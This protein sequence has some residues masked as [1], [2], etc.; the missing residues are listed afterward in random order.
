MVRRI[1]L[2]ISTTLIAVAS[3]GVFALGLGEISLKSNLNQPVNAEIQLLEIRDLTERDI[4]VRLGSQQDF[5]RL[6]LDRSYFLTDLKFSV[7]LE[8]TSGAVILVTSN[9]PVREPFLDFVIEARWPSGRLLREYT[10]LLD[11]PVFAKGGASKIA[12]ARSTTNNSAQPSNQQAVRSAPSQGVNSRSSYDQGLSASNRPSVSRPAYDGDTYQVK[13]NDTLWEIALEVR[14]DRDVSVHQ[15]MMALQQSNPDAFINGNIN[16]LKKGQVLRIPDSDEIRGLQR[17]EAVRAVAQQNSEWLGAPIDASR[18]LSSGSTESSTNEGRLSLSSPDDSYNAN[19]GRVSG[20]SGS[21]STDAL[22]TE[23]GATQETLDKTSR[24]N[25]ELRTRVAGLEEQIETLEGMIA[26]SNDSLRELELSAANN[27]IDEEL[28]QQDATLAGVDASEEVASVTE[29]TSPAEVTTDAANEASTVESLSEEVVIAPVPATTPQK[30]EDATTSNVKKE[31]AKKTPK[32]VKRAPVK[33]GIV[34]YLMDY[35]ILIGAGVALLVLVIVLIIRSKKSDDEYED[36]FLDTVGDFDEADLDDTEEF[37]LGDQAD[38]DGEEQ[39]EAFEEEP[40]VAAEEEDHSSEAETG[41]VVGEAYIYIAYGK[42][43]QAEEMLVSALETD[44][45]HHEARIKLLEVHAAQ[46]N[47]Q[48]FDPH[49]AR[50]LS[51]GTEDQVER[52]DGL[53]ASIAGAEPFDENMYDVSDITVIAPVNTETAD[54]GEDSSED[55]AEGLG[56]FELDDLDFSLESDEQSDEL[57]TEINLALSEDEVKERYE[58]SNGAE[59]A[60]PESDDHG[61]DFGLDDVTV[62]SNEDNEFDLELSD[63]DS[64]FS[65]EPVAESEG[66]IEFDLES[67]DFDLD[68]DSESEEVES[69]EFVLDLDDEDGLGDLDITSVTS[70]VADG[71]DLSLDIDG[72]GSDLELDSA[73]LDI[74]TSLDDID[75]ELA[76]FDE[77]KAEEDDESLDSSSEFSLELNSEADEGDFDLDDFDLESLDSELDSVNDESPKEL[78]IDELALDDLE[79]TD[80]GLTDVEVAADGTSSIDSAGLEAAVEDLSV[81]D[82]SA[83]AE[84]EL[85]SIDA[86]LDPVQD[87]EDETVIREGVSQG[88]DLSLG[89]DMD[90]DLD[91]LDQELEALTS[92]LDVSDMDLELPGSN[93]ES[94]G[95]N[96]PEESS[97]EVGELEPLTVAEIV[98]PDEVLEDI[99]KPAAVA[100]SD[101]FDDFDLDSLSLDGAEDEELAIEGESGQVGNDADLSLDEFGVD[102][103][104]PVVDFDEP[105][106][107]LEDESGLSLEEELNEL[108]DEPAVEMAEPDLSFDVLPIESDVVSDDVLGDDSALDGDDIGF[109]LPELSSDSE[110][111][112]DLNFLLSAD[113]TKTKIELASAYMDSDVND[114]AREILQEILKFNEGSDEQRR[115]VKE[116]LGRL[117]D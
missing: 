76:G 64:E 55:S 23:L 79:L 18:S 74:A 71:S 29:V 9:R 57:D 87:D 15:T 100:A 33:K 91:A 98:E 67:L 113:Q 75:L 62:I 112:Q 39:P 96:D 13:S 25:T 80:L 49:Y 102:L 40:E 30:A 34:D 20:R 68:D 89:T 32:V 110:D 37:D 94:F 61:I 93:I 45:N 12:P 86:L 1:G 59:E 38:I 66:D 35:I 109:E 85:D 11:L 115:E 90:F 50:I 56:E 31:N 48:A 78:V 83:F 28:A 106:L 104:E 10:V 16:R 3:K 36:D 103:E 107:E 69:N 70:E 2:L 101:D 26:I 58:E 116:M 54:I 42:L 72:S 43:D 19:E 51:V 99:E 5:D 4:I 44:P 88:D 17:G 92:D 6:G 63:A 77:T 60:A 65:V 21:S 111:D 73:E 53:R 108:A 47:V 14:P 52:A 82:A 41:D 84:A 105:G 24:E 97:P 46:E 22:E 8:A 27:S 117:D 95:A 7:D 114:G 81:E